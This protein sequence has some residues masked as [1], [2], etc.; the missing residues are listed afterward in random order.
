MIKILWQVP[1]VRS[2]Y[3]KGD[4]CEILNA[5]LKILIIIVMHVRGLNKLELKSTPTVNI[6]YISKP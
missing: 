2:M 5:I 1:E 6:Y 3:T 4:Y